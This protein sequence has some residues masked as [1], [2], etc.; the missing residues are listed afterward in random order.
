[1]SAYLLDTSAVVAHYQKEVGHA[2][3]QALFD[4]EDAVLWLAAPSLLEMEACLRDIGLDA[5]IRRKTVDA[6]ANELMHIVAVDER[7]VRRAIEIRDA[8]VGRLPAMDALISACAA[9]CGAV[10]VHRDSHFDTIPQQVLPSLRLSSK[11]DEAATATAA[12]NVVKEAR[13]TYKTRR[14]G[15]RTIKSGSAKRSPQV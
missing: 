15:R 11:D 12:W 14:K 9:V 1:M 8:A 5:A 3:V 13:V 7:V 2:R 4:D 6:Y 10:L